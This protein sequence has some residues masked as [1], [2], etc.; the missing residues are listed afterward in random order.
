M[1]ASLWIKSLVTV[2]LLVVFL[3]FV[4]NV[5]I[6]LFLCA[7]TIPIIK[8]TEV[9]AIQNNDGEVHPMFKNPQD[10]EFV[11][12]LPTSKDLEESYFIVFMIPSHPSNM[13]SREVI[14]NTWANVAGWS[15]LKDENAYKKKI[16]VMFVCGSIPSQNFTALFEEEVAEKDDMFVVKNITEGRTSLRY[17]EMWAMRYAHEHYNFIYLV[18]TDDDVTVNLPVLIR[19][20]AALPRGYHYMGLC[21]HNVGSPPQRWKYCSGGGYV[22][23]RDLITEMLHLPDTVHIPRMKPEDVFTGWLV[24]NVNNNTQHAVKARY[25]HAAL[26]LHP[27]KCGPLNKW[28]YHGYKNV[29]IEERQRDVQN[30]FMDNSPVNCT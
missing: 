4:T 26:A 30:Y 17:K 16:R 15:L 1:L 27:Y 12:I 21:M 20:L 13:N 8:T 2:T 7:R 5:D 9:N 11:D 19:D 3:V 18:K 28:F 23:S 25:V 22:L 29:D 10:R 14:R 6:G 24:W